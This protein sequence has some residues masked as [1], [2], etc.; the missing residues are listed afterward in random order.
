MLFSVFPSSVFATTQGQQGIETNSSE[1]DV[2]K[3]TG[4]AN[5][6][7]DVAGDTTV[8]TEQE[9]QGGSEQSSWNR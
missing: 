8:S 5:D 2:S 7:Q 3:S 1:E 6:L 4:N 9:N